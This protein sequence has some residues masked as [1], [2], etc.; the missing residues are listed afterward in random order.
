LVQQTG[1]KEYPF[2][3]MPSHAQDCGQ[4]CHKLPLLG[5]TIARPSSLGQYPRSA[6]GFP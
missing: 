2:F 5:E 4:S 3:K 1:S 6:W